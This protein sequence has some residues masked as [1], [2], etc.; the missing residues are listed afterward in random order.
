[1]LEIINN[2]VNKNMLKLFKGKRIL[3]LENDYSLPEDSGENLARWLI[4]QKIEHNALY[5]LEALP[6]DYIMDQIQW[7]DVIVFETTWTYDIAKKLFD[8]ITK[9]SRKKIFVEV[10]IDK[11]SWYRKPKGIVHDLYIIQT[12]GISMNDWKFEKLK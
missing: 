7:F 11:P 5:N 12:Y 2:K 4:E 3:F 8:A 9:M 6:F 1:M 10:Y